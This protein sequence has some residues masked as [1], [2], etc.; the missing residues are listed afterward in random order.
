MYLG[1]K[2]SPATS[3]APKKVAAEKKP[4]PP[5]KKPAVDLKKLAGKTNFL[6]VR[7]CQKLCKPIC[8]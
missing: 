4:P 7:P 8:K 3:T 1:S 6:C 5:K 2:A